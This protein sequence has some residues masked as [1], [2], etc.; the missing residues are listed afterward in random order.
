MAFI[1][2]THHSHTLTI[3]ASKIRRRIATDIDFRLF[4]VLIR[5]NIASKSTFRMLLN[6]SAHSNALDG[7]KGGSRTLLSNMFSVLYVNEILNKKIPSDQIPHKTA[8]YIRNR[9]QEDRRSE[10][11][12]TYRRTKKGH[13]VLNKGRDVPHHIFREAFYVD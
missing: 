4:F 3:L 8:M 10:F 1:N 9:L 11:D 6:A 7:E 12:A 5:E 2:D 13:W